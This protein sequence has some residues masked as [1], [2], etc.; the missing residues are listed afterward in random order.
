MRESLR[1]AKAAGV[2]H[3][4]YVSVAHPAPV[5]KAYVAVREW[6]EI[7]IRASGLPGT[8]LRPWYI[9]GPGHYWPLLLIPAY[10]LL[11]MFPRTRDG[12]RRLGLVTIGQMV[13]ALTWA[14][15][16]PATGVRI[17][18]VPAIRHGA[19]KDA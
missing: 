16:H 1:A 6:C 3:F 17:M 11:E 4:V 8:I 9:V 13:T 2:E 14:V 19:T 12:A 5:M 7:Q 18:D 15:E 10:R